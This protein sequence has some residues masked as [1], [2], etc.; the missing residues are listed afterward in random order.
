MIIPIGEAVTITTGPNEGAVGVVIHYEAIYLPKQIRGYSQWAYEYTVR[1]EVE[2]GY[3]WE[4]ALADQI[5]KHKKEIH[6]IQNSST[7]IVL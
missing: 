7:P 5:V 6:E 2:S 1:I 3:L 4:Y